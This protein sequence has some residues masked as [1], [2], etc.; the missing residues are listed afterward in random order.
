[1][2]NTDTLCQAL[3]QAQSVLT[4]SGAVLLCESPY[5]CVK[6]YHWAEEFQP[7]VYGQVQHHHFEVHTLKGKRTR[8]WF[9]VTVARLDSGRYETVAYFL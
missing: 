2:S 8:K 5:F 6:N 9:H 3:A 1:M 4:V 7:L